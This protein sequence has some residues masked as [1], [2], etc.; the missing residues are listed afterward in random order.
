MQ[1]DETEIRYDRAIEVHSQE[2]KLSCSIST[3]GQHPMGI[4]LQSF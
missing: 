3:T 1:I 2:H 4:K